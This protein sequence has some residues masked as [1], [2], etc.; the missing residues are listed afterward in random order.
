ML[1]I[2]EK[3]ISNKYEKIIS[4]KYEYS[5]QVYNLNPS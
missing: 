1:S 3:I 2:I 5:C 4:N